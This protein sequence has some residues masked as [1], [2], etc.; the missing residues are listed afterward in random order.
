MAV[1]AS[2][3]K[4]QDEFK[5]SAF[6]DRFGSKA[7]ETL[8]NCDVCITPESRHPGMGCASSHVP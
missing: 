5:L 7:D 2:Q 8:F 4:S 6:K 3:A 1:A